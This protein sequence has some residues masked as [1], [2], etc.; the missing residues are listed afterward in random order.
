MTIS[1][2]TTI[3]NNLA[4]VFGGGV[5]NAGAMSIS[6]TTTIAKNAAAMGAGVSNRGA[7][8]IDGASIVGNSVLP[9]VDVRP[10]RQDHGHRKQI[11]HDPS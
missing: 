11:G 8:S 6:G 1:G 7:M 9:S 2:A 4:I 3:A 5:L 10:G